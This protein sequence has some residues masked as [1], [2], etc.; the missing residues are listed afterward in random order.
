MPR[1]PRCPASTSSSRSRRVRSRNRSRRSVSSEMLRRRSPASMRPGSSSGSRMPFVV[2]AS[3]TGSPSGPSIDAR[4][5]TTSTMSVRSSGSP[6]VRRN[7]VMPAAAATR[8]TRSISSRVR[9]LDWASHSLPCSGMQ[10]VQRSEQRSVSEMRRSR[11]TRPWVSTSGEPA[12]PERVVRARDGAVGAE[13]GIRTP[14]VT[15]TALTRA[16]PS[17]PSRPCIRA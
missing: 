4:R 3:S 7:V 2:I 11:C 16:R 13:R 10:Y 8:A 17:S 6:P 15:G 12:S 5:R 14:I 1:P 9:M